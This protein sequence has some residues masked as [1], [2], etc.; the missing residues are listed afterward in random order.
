M[1]K[2]AATG[3]APWGRGRSGLAMLAVALLGLALVAALLVS[4]PSANSAEGD[5][6]DTASPTASGP[7]PV[8]PAPPPVQS[9]PAN[10]ANTALSD[11]RFA[12][13]LV[14][15]AQSYDIEVST[16]DRFTAASQ[17]LLQRTTSTRFTPLS[18]FQP[19]EYWWR[20]RGVSTSGVSK[21]SGAWQFRQAW[22][23][24]PTGSTVARP[25]V[26]SVAGSQPVNATV[27]SWTAI[28]GASSYEVQFAKDATFKGDTITCTTPHATLTPYQDGAVDYK[29]VPGGDPCSI[30]DAVPPPG[31]PFGVTA[32]ISAPGEVTVSWSAPTTGGPATT[33]YIEKSTNNGGT[34]IQT[35]PAQ[36]TET[37]V[38]ITTC[39]TVGVPV[40][41]R[42]VATNAGGAGPY[43]GTSAPVVPTAPPTPTATATGTAAPGPTTPTATAACPTGRVTL[44]TST[45]F[46]VGDTVYYRV[47]AV[48]ARVTPAEDGPTPDIYS[49]WSDQARSVG[50][51]PPGPATYTVTAAQTGPGAAP[52][53][54]SGLATSGT[55]QT[56]CVTSGGVACYADAPVMSWS[57]VGTANSVYTVVLATDRDFVNRIGAFTT[58]NT[59]LIPSQVLVDNNSESYYWFVLACQKTD[60][61]LICPADRDAINQPGKY[62]VFRKVGSAIS[63]PSGQ[64]KT[65]K[66]N[67]T[68]T[69]NGAVPGEG[70]TSNY[71]LQVATDDLFEPELS[72]GSIVEEIVTDNPSFTVV[73]DTLYPDGIYYWRVA[74]VDGGDKRLPWS[75]TQYVKVT[76]T[77]PPNPTVVSLTGT[78]NGFQ[79]RWTGPGSDGGSYITGFRVSW[80]FGKNGSWKRQS[81]SPSVR[82]LRV[83][84]IKTGRE[85]RVVVQAQNAKGYSQNPPVTTTTTKRR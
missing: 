25:S 73:D 66:S 85:V 63:V 40:V 3:G 52:G 75:A 55:T 54:P 76:T 60:Q 23:D 65:Q 35:V 71:V 12:W 81:V 7:F 77:V 61:R 26:T 78:K 56:A 69:W 14:P 10:N 19:G 37:S 46:N 47:R 53:V 6:T 44:P 49:L 68:F 57:P 45:V 39:L 51:V 83:T 33:Y 43:S 62:G 70:G 4:A 48:D 38:K 11:I 17:V 72:G 13:S 82:S 8:W 84:G 32:T 74:A 22:T 41:F 50:E 29:G 79:V 30:Y 20:V 5:P 15:G 64:A 27:L 67:I 42:V 21:W 24:P 80:K 59:R 31:A 16:S 18:E 1:S 28:A 58:G 9:A 2:H 36:S 34:W